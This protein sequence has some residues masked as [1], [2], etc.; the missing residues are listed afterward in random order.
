MDAATRTYV[1]DLA[2]WAP[3]VDNAQPFRFRWDGERLLV[4]RDAGRDRTRGNAGNFA[5]HVGLGCL[6]EYI[7]IA[8]SESNHEIELAL[9]EDGVTHD[10]PCAEVAFVAGGETDELVSGLRL[11]RSDR[12]P[13]EG[14]SLE[15]SVFAE[16][17]KDMDQFA[18]CRLH[19]LDAAGPDLMRYLLDAEALMWKDPHLLPEMLSWV[20]WSQREADRTRDGMPWQAVGVNFVVSRVMYLLSRSATLRRLARG[21]R[22][23]E[24]RQREQARRSIDSSGALGC[25]T[26]SEPMPRAMVQVGRAFAR[27]WLR[28]NLAGYGLQVMASPA[29]HALQHAVGVL[30][31]DIPADCRRTFAL[32]RDLLTRAF[33]ASS[34]A[35]PV[36]MFRTGV[37]STLPAKMR[38][39][40]RPLDDWISHDEPG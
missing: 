22:G 31:A 6:L 20:R 29:L 1:L 10:G 27:A 33:G 36:W 30:P 8:A 5:S 11:R 26:T 13:Y 25:F 38:T 39:R 3:N 21:A 12:R 32:G 14:G 28:L 18:A 9:P 23:P 24:R 7:R 15:D 19:L 16:T 2:R 34:E 35:Y 40:R 17:A 37:S 4:L